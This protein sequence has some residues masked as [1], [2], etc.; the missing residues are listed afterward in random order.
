MK[1]VAA[2]FG[3][4]SERHFLLLRCLVLVFIAMFG[5]FSIRAQ[6]EARPE[7][8]R[9]D[10]KVIA[11]RVPAEIGEIC[12]QCLRPVS[13]S[14][15]AFQVQGQRVVLHANEIEPNLAA[16]LLRLAA[17]IQ[18]KGAFLGA[19][20]ES[21]TV[22]PI[23]F[24]TG[25]YVLAGLL[26]GALSSHRALNNGYGAVSWFFIGL[27]FTLPGYLYLLTRPRREIV[28]PAGVPSGL[29]KIAATYAPVPCPACGTENHP[30]ASQCAG[31][32][33]RL[34]AKFTSEVARAGLR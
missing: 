13:E 3:R 23:W 9:Q 28:F 7:E 5:A 22:S 4:L 34:E 15:S 24:F 25:L 20:A 26:F 31:C 10:G 16:Q 11:R 30:T 12:T 2:Q 14:D 19:G 1:S 33:A 8:I 17:R 27:L 6:Q 29:G 21:A 18:P 32:G